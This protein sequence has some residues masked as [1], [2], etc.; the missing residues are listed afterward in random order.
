M[1]G[2]KVGPTNS[3]CRDVKREAPLL[4]LLDTGSRKRPRIS[5][6]GHVMIGCVWVGTTEET[7]EHD[8][9]STIFLAVDRRD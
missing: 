5:A 9:Q 2:G 4:P 6:D 1:G 3:V 7:T 8:L